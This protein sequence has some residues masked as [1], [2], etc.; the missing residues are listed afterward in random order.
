MNVHTDMQP[1]LRHQFR[2]QQR[3]AESLMAGTIRAG[4]AGGADSSSVLPINV[5][6]APA[7][8]LLMSIKPDDPP[9]ADAF[10]ICA[11]ATC[12]PFLP[13]LL[14]IPPV[15]GMGD[16]AEQMAK[17][18]VRSVNSRTRY[19][20]FTSAP[21]RHGRSKLAEEVMTTHVPPYKTPLQKYFN[22]I[23]APPRWRTTPNLRPCF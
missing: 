13:P 23:A 22:N 10:F 7:R 4:I 8:V 12:R 19:A 3:M 6:K 9:T 14:S 2:W 1:R 18:M 20:S 21:R 15:R 5:S 17:R 16:T 11:Y